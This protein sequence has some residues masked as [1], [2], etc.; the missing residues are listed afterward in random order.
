MRGCRLA[1]L[2]K[3]TV[4]IFVA[5]DPCP[6]PFIVFITPGYGAVIQGHAN[7]PKTRIFSQ[8]FQMERWMRRVLDKLLI[9][10]ARGGFYRRGQFMVG[11]PEVWRAMRGHPRSSKSLSVRTGKSSGFFALCASSLSPK[12]VSELLG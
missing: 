1:L 10:G 4:K 12:A 7:R 11:L 5:A 9:G 6:E 3:Q 2:P 8:P